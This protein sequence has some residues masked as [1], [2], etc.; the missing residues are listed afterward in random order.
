VGAAGSPRG[1]R[2]R[3]AYAS[4]DEF[5]SH[6]HGDCDE[7]S[8]FVPTAKKIGAGAE[9][10]FSIELA[11][12]TPML[13]GLGVVQE[14]WPTNENPFR[15]PGVLVAFTQLTEQSQR[16][17][18][19]LLEAQ[20]AA[21][22][23]RGRSRTSPLTRQQWGNPVAPPT[24][25]MAAAQPLLEK[26]ATAPPRK[27]TR[28]LRSRAANE[29]EAE[30]P[31]AA[32]DAEAAPPASAFG[33]EAA[34]L[35]ALDEKTTE[36]T[37]YDAELRAPAPLGPG[38]LPPRGLPAGS[39]AMPGSGR[40]GSAPPVRGSSPPASVPLPGV[41]PLPAAPTDGSWPSQAS[42][43]PARASSPSLP[44]P[45]PAAFSPMPAPR[46]WNPMAWLRANPTAEPGAGPWWRSRRVAAV[47]AAGIVLG[48]VMGLLIRPS[49]TRRNAE[50]AAVASSPPLAR[51]PAVA[52]PAPAASAV[53]ATAAPSTAP[54]ASAAKKLGT[55]PPAAHTKPRGASRPVAIATSTKPHASAAP[56]PAP[57]RPARASPPVARK[58]EG[59]RPGS[60]PA[61]THPKG[62]VR[63]SRKARC[64]SLLCI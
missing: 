3:T 14:A 64:S 57:P 32:F 62:H 15:R 51:C 31:A 12:G 30:P 61:A 48:L 11:D 1:I 13:R 47:F 37:R 7:S 10:A 6:A 41:P 5:V 56:S 33:A 59:D 25:E 40:G 46:S 20:A 4:Q 8:V 22:P 38:N 49:G 24:A 53:V 16:S 27:V 44:A 43:P 58:A 45:A 39:P 54:H 18:Q 34:P 55:K 35:A 19:R 2:V 52:A 28:E 60:K 36:T 42:P 63:R 23:A 29:A 26:P 17:L 21:G 50:V 9:C